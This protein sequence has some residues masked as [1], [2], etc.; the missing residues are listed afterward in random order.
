MNHNIY[1][2]GRLPKCQ[3]LKYVFSLLFHF[4]QIISSKIQVHTLLLTGGKKH[5]ILCNMCKIMSQKTLKP[6]LKSVSLVRLTTDT[7][8][9]GSLPVFTQ[10]C[11]FPSVLAEIPCSMCPSP[12]QFSGGHSGGQQVALAATTVRRMSVITGK[13]HK[14]NWHLM[15]HGR[16]LC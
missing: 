8:H 9:L 11:H 16:S 2:Y 12:L 6:S 14:N 5:S 13:R 3:I 15:L 4:I 10:S 7:G 1:C